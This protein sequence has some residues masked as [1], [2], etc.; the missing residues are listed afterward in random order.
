MEGNLTFFSLS[1]SGALQDTNGQ[2]LKHEHFLD[3]TFVSNPL[4]PFLIKLKIDLG[5]S[6]FS[7]TLSDLFYSGLDLAIYELIPHIFWDFHNLKSSPK[8]LINTTTIP[9]FRNAVISSLS[10]ISCFT[11]FCGIWAVLRQGGSNLS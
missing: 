2:G 3:F 10:C 1:F 4:P 11:R 5:S 9:L 8:S 6:Y 7:S